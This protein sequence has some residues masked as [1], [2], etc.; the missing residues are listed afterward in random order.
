MKLGGLAMAFCNF[1]SFLAEPRA[2]SEQ[3]ADEW[4]PYIE[5]CIE[6]FGAERCMFESNFPVDM[7]SCSYATLWNAFKRIAKGGSA[8]GE[9]GA[10]LRD[11]D[12]GLPAGA[13]GAGHSVKADHALQVVEEGL[14]PVGQD[15]R[16]EHQRHAVEGAGVG[17][18]IA[19]HDDLAGVKDGNLVKAMDRPGP[20]A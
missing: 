8:D 16:L 3:L 4:G 2:P 10:V 12:A 15:T 19:F 1:P 6:A 11:G 14:R 7:G 5:T 18:R 9:G 13:G 17:R 20:G